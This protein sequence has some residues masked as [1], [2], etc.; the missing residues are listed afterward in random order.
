MDIAKS[1]K[2]CQYARKAENSDYVG[3]CI[4]V[5]KEP[6]DWFAFYQKKVINTGWV[7][8]RAKPNMKN[9]GMITNGIPYFKP[10]DICKH[11]KMEENND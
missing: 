7:D 9:S 1:C 4:A 3:C 6:D 11:Y 8:L 5:N 10:D 2:T